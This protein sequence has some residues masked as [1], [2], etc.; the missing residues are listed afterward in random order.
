M[1]NN[2]DDMSKILDVATRILD[3]YMEKLAVSCFQSD[4]ARLSNYRYGVDL[5]LNSSQNGDFGFEF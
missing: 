2:F 3:Q 5:H 4:I 1:S